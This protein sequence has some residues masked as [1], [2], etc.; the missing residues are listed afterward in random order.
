MRFRSTGRSRQQAAKPPADLLAPFYG[1]GRRGV[2]KGKGKPRLV[3]DQK[4]ERIFRAIYFYRYMGALD[5]AYRLYSPGAL[6]RVR[7]TLLALSGDGDFVAREYLY[8]FQL[9]GEGNPERVYTL[10]SRG[11]DYLANEVGLPV[12]W[13]FRPEMVKH[14]SHAHVVH[15]LL[16]TRVLV[17]AEQWARSQEGIRL[18]ARRIS[19]ELWVSPPVVE[20][21]AEDGKK[22]VKVV[23]DA[24]LLFE[25]PDGKRASVLVEIDRGREYQAAFKAH[26]AARLEFIASGQYTRVFGTRGVTIAYA[27]TGERP[28]YGE[29]RVSRMRQWTKEVLVNQGRESWAELFRFCTLSLDTVYQLPL[30]SG[31]VW[32]RIGSETPVALFGSAG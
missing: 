20:I 1:F 28:E 15:S 2:M 17:A 32:R 27:T 22:E 13:Y 21:D 7:K 8:R 30:F 12:T 31:P 10:G 29:A 19:Y 24:W 6:A 11:R 4:A 18:A 14:F 23:P 9:P 26:V 16:L 3:L 5:V 25:R